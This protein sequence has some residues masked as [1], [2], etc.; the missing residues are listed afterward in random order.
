MDDFAKVFFGPP[1]N[2]AD[3]AP[4]VKP[5]TFDDLVAAL[6]HV[7]PNDWR[8]FL[9]DRVNY[10]GP[11]APLGGIEGSGWR[12]VYTDTPS[13]LQKTRDSLEQAGGDF[14]YSLGLIVNRAGRVGDSIFFM[15]A[16]AAGIVPGM[17]IVAVNGRKYSA[18]VLRDA[19]KA[20]MNNSA[21]IQLLMENSE[22]YKTYSVNYHD[23][24]RYPHLVRDTSKPDYLADIIRPHVAAA[25]PPK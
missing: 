14:S 7:A 19:L 18:D 6:N 16:H 22:Y 15:P 23:G 21:P 3:A 2:P 11:N 8:T 9:L 10:V 13:D 4:K 1:D 5:Y 24:E 25:V 20:A 17:T 12:L